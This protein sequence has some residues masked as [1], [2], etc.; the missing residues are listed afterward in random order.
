MHG[1]VR[2]VKGKC[3]YTETGSLYNIA[4]TVANFRIGWQLA[5]PKKGSI[6]IPT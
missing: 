1:L 4:I 3:S 5:C 2:Q 6:N